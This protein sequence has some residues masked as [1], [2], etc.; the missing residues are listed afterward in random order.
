MLI[1]VVVNVFASLFLSHRLTVVS[2]KAC[3]NTHVFDRELP[4]CL[5]LH[6]GPPKNEPL[7]GT[8]NHR[9]NGKWDLT[10]SSELIPSV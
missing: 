8:R 10:A 2:K 5:A 1:L 3:E 4:D 9:E 7:K 6:F